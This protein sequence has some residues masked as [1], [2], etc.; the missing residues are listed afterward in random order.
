MK[1]RIFIKKWIFVCLLVCIVLFTGCGENKDNSYSK[2]L[3]KIFPSNIN[4]TAKYIGLAEYGHSVTIENIKKETDTLTYY[5]EGYLDDARGDDYNKRQ[6]NINYI[7]DNSSIKEIIINNDELR[8]DGK[9]NRINSIIPNQTILKLPLEL[10]NSWE[11][12]F[13]YKNK[14]YI[15]ETVIIGI[16]LTDEGT[17]QYVTK[18]IIDNIPGYFN[19]KYIEERIYEEGKGLISFTNTMEQYETDI[20]PN[21]DDF[22]FGYQQISIK[23]IK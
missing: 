17:K 10:G 18:I 6:F 19:N 3:A 15:A 16:K 14:S 1:G 22:M 23:S 11:Q 12:E 20:D 7:I 8:Q 9:D 21:Q 4:T 5:I 2:D 13:T